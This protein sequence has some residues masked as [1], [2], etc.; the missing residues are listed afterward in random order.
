MHTVLICEILLKIL[1]QSIIFVSMI[2]CL[3][4]AYTLDANGLSVIDT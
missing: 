2:C 1:F 3:N 4:N